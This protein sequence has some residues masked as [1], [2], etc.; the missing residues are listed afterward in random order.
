MTLKLKKKKLP[1][2]SALKQVL[3][4]AS[5]FFLIVIFCLMIPFPYS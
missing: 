3:D 4:F 1:E 5:S 2:I